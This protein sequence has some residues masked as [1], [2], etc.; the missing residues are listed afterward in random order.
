MRDASNSGL[1][2]TDQQFKNAVEFAVGMRDAS[3]SGLKRFSVASGSGVGSGCVGMRDA[4]NSGLKP[5]VMHP[6]GFF[7]ALE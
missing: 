1:K 2:L 3:N 7:P 4:S 6:Y 5:A